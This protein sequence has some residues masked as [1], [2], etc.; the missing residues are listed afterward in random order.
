[1]KILV[2]D[3]LAAAGLERL[4]AEATVVSTPGGDAKTLHA[5]IADV[6]A[7][8]VRSQTRIDRAAIA[9]A[10]RLRV[11]ARAGVGVDNIDLDTATRRGILVLTTP[12]SSTVSAAEH[13]MAMLLASARDLPAAHA[14]TVQGSWERERF[15]GTELYGKT[16]GIIGLGKIG[17]EVARRA[18]A[19]GMRVIGFDPYVSADRAAKV[20]VELLSM[21]AVLE[22]SDFLTL[23]VP[24]SARTR[25]LLGRVQF[26]QMR[27][28]VRIVN[29]AR[30]GL[31]DEV[32]L[33]AALEDG[34]V[35]RAALDVFEQEPPRGSPLLRHP[36][37]VVTPHLGASTEEAQRGIGI[38]VAEQVLAALAGRP[39][40][41]AVNAPAMLAEDWQR[42]RPFADLLHALGAVA[43]QLVSGQVIGV[44]IVY[45]GQIA[46]EQTQSLS[47]SLLVGLLASVLDQPVNLVNAAIL[48]KERGIN[49]SEVHRDTSE[50]FSSLIRVQVDST[51][52]PLL[53][54]G[55][56]FGRREPRITHL[57]DYRIDLVP[58]ARMLFVWNRDRPGMIGRVGSI[59]GS[60]HVN[61]AGMQVG[62][63]A[64]GGTAV[65]VLTI[66]TPVPDAAITEIA[67]V[68]GITAVKVVDL[69]PGGESASGGEGGPLRGEK[70]VDAEATA[71]LGKPE[72]KGG[73]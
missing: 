22:R 24:L 31:I 44:E 3:G 35:A 36:R 8:I 69:E 73:S 48:A 52:G 66:D 10:S 49:L 30:G 11:I 37:V 20:G 46:A 47:A 9:A 43:S 41:G 63:T 6:D 64:P 34:R 71:G 21:D 68:D 56:L 39:V 54:G 32:A 1:M 55:T 67:R 17:S 7:V 29:C 2:T 38:E 70:W 26:A 65:M 27:P 23:H 72:R 61:I 60:H 57:N 16:M 42:L 4:Q 58:S 50:D 45:E 53:V 12:E 62:R 33:L 14:A 18:S 5:A 25:H 28:G 15:L 19:F 59:L 51:H 40:K 13:T